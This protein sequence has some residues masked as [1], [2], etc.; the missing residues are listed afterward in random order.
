MVQ[1][2]GPEA[3]LIIRVLVT[4]CSISQSRWKYK[5][6]RKKT[7][8]VW[9]SVHCYSYWGLLEGITAEV[10]W[11]DD[12]NISN[13]LLRRDQ[14]SP[15]WMNER[16]R[17]VFTKSFKLRPESFSIICCTGRSRKGKWLARLNSTTPF[18]YRTSCETAK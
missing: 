1:Y 8:I 5:K 4:Q 3:D 13:V 7:C 9:C 10:K 18:R 17:K 12:G 11:Y 14:G 15:F 6:R 2:L 16:W